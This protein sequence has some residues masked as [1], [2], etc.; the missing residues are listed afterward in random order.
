MNHHV[1]TYSR[2]AFGL[3]AGRPVFLYA[4]LP[5]HFQTNTSLIA[6]FRMEESVRPSF[7]KVTRAAEAHFARELTESNTD[8]TLG[9]S[10]KYDVLGVK[11]RRKKIAV[12][13]VH[14]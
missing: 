2:I 3:C 14:E 10:V 8:N 13:C 12:N 5:V 9:C 6:A 11:I 4:S 1:T 7:C